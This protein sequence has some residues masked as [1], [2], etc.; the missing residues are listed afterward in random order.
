M[1]T[2]N[3]PGIIK[4]TD[5]FINRNRETIYLVMDLIEGSSVK[6]FVNKY[7][8]E[9]GLMPYGG[10]PESLCKSITR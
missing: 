8:E 5:A 7:G 4:M 2:L 3:H 1:K 10:L 9:K 6:E